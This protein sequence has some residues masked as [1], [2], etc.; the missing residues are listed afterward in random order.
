MSDFFELLMRFFKAAAPA[1]IRRL[2]NG[3]MYDLG[4]S[5]L[6]F[7][8]R[9]F[10]EGWD[11]IQR[12]DSLVDTSKLPID[13]TFTIGDICTKIQKEL[14][15]GKLT[16]ETIDRI[17]TLPELLDSASLYYQEKV[18]AS[19]QEITRISE[20]LAKDEADLKAAL[21]SKD[22]DVLL[23]FYED[24]AGLLFDRDEM[25]EDI[26]DVTSLER[27]RCADSMGVLANE[28]MSELGVRITSAHGLGT[29]TVIS[30]QRNA[31]SY[32]QRDIERNSLVLAGIQDV[33]KHIRE[34]F[35]PT[36]AVVHEADV[37]VLSKF[38]GTDRKAQPLAL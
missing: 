8:H 14:A 16:S 37:I 29:P 9:I 32:L 6:D 11:I 13:A 3:G 28:T 19:Q 24:C 38:R 4:G 21:L 18:A 36:P 2:R 26:G 1:G 7:V 23:R 20:K 12:G 5:N 30:K 10:V 27:R 35:D 15:T 22:N 25:P 31:I 33:A 17:R 34:I